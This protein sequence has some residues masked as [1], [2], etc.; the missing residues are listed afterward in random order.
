M[1][2]TRTPL[3]RDLRKRYAVAA[4]HLGHD[5]AVVRL[6]GVYGLAAVADDWLDEGSPGRA[7]TCVDV[8]C[9]YLRMAIDPVS[10]A[11]QDVR[12]AITALLADRLRAAAGETSWSGLRID[13]SG[14]DLPAADF[15][16]A[17]FG[18]NATFARAT[19]EKTAWFTHARF[20]ADATF[21]GATFVGPAGFT[22]AAFLS[23][24]SFAEATFYAAA[25]FTQ[26]SFAAET[27]F[28]GT[29]FC[30]PTGFTGTTFSRFGPDTDPFEDAT[31]GPDQPAGE[32]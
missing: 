27:G 31:F 20:E 14:A 22:G 29:R 17:V 2:F 11:E 5:K 7:Q 3:L 8:L 23:E 12:A 18:T 24:A 16:A 4:T 6:A 32:T 28:G 15:T 10:T 25:G 13:L 30:G 19:F 26:A 21:T 1:S 9:G